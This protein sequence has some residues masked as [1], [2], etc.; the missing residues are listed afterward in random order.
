MSNE[1]R[2]L[3]DRVRKLLEAMPEE[4]REF[5]VQTT[6]ASAVSTIVS[7]THKLVVSIAN[8]LCENEMAFA[9][10]VTADVV[11]DLLEMLK[12]NLL[13]KVTDSKES[14]AA[15]KGAMSAL[16]DKIDDGIF[17]F[18]KFDE[19]LKHVRMSVVTNKI[20]AYTKT[21]GSA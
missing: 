7:Q 1:E 14:H 21:R 19:D 4:K 10:M 8:E 18:D 16:R 15:Y 9:Y 13:L 5:L 11:T 3:R 6:A 2:E 12:L 17:D 20:E